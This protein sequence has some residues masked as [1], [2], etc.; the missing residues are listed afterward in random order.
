MA[1]HVDNMSLKAEVPRTAE[2]LRVC[3]QVRRRFGWQPESAQ[4]VDQVRGLGDLWTVKVRTGLG[5]FILIVYGNGLLVGIP[6]KKQGQ[7]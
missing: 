6:P 7:S 5:R 2:Q 4:A 1:R 3:D